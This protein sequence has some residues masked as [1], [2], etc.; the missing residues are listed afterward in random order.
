MKKLLTILL[1]TGLILMGAC[2]KAEGEQGVKD[3]ASS[4]KNVVSKEG[5]VVSKSSNNKQENV[6]KTNATDS[7]DSSINEST[8]TT[9]TDSGSAS[10]DTEVGQNEE[11]TK[12]ESLGTDLNVEMYLNEHYAIENTHYSLDTWE[13]EETGRTEYIVRIMPNTE[14]FGEEIEEVFENG[15]PY[16][17]D[18]RTENMFKVAEK[19]LVDLPQLDDKV[20]IE[21]VLWSTAEDD[22]F[23][24]LLIQDRAQSTI[25]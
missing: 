11:A 9:E 24:I 12:N 6:G 17:D 7:E 13:N 22:E 18:E 10:E 4:T 5:N 19:L 21:S 25:N 23:P 3:A 2:S 14:Q 15:N 8:D 20:H 16:M 1:L